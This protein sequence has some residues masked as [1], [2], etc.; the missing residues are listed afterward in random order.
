VRESP[1]RWTLGL[2]LG[3][4]FLIFSAIAWSTIASMWRTEVR[5]LFDLTFLLFKGFWVLGWLVGVVILGGLTAVVVFGVGSS[6]TVRRGI[7]VRPLMRSAIEPVNANPL[8]DGLESPQPLTWTSTI[9]LIAANLVPLAGVLF[10]GW[11]LAGVLLLYWAESAVIG[12]YTVLKIVVVNRLASLVAVPFFAGHFG[13]F[14]TMHFFFIY[15][16]FIAG[17]NAVSREGDVRATL[18]GIFAPLWLPLTGLFISHGVSFA[19]NFVKGGEY[20]RTTVKDLM[21]APYNRIVVMQLALIGGGWI[22]ML[23]MRPTPALALLILLKTA[24]DLSAHQ[25]EHAA[26]PRLSSS[27]HV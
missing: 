2:F 14:M 11:D 25:R 3:A 9:A 5:D 23:L 19:E 20:R 12:V 8:S 21:T 17:I 22:V 16:F 27:S 6:G 10:F 18:L 13:G 4:A 24:V 1:T 26:Q 7:S 15:A